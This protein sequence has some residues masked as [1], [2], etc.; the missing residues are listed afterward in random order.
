MSP[1][2]PRSRRR[3]ILLLGGG[4]VLVLAAAVAAFALTRDT[5]DVS[6]PEVEF[7]SEPEPPAPPPAR[8]ARRDTFVWP[9][10]GYT[11]DRRRFLP[12]RPRLRPPLRRVWR[13]RT[14]VLLE[15]TPVMAGRWLYLLDDAAVLRAID[16]RTGETRWRRK[17]G[18][19]AA[20]S[21]AYAKGRLFVTIL[22]RAEG[23][24]GRVTALR[25]RD[26]KVLW[27]EALPSRSESSPVVDDGQVI[28]GS[29][30]GTVY[31]VRASNGATRWR[32]RAQGAVKGGPA[33][34]DGRLYF[35]DYAGRVYAIRQSDGREVWQVG[36][37]GTRFGF[38]SGRF[39]ATPAVAFGRVYLG[40]T[41][42]SV[43][44]FAKSSGKLAWRTSTGHYVYASPAVA[45]L[46][47]SRPLVFTGSYDG[48]FY[49]MDARSGEVRWSYA[50]GGK[51]SGGATV[52]GD[53]V[54]VSNTG[55]RRTTALWA[56]TGKRRWSF[57]DGAYAS[58]I[59][60]GRWI[61]LNGKRA[62]YGFKPKP[63]RRGR[64]R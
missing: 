56:R 52:V 55:L 18:A 53:V 21:P 40:N 6:H 31:S 19:L 11:A 37:S 61:F 32:F 64:A 9:F 60:D 13:K 48:R 22:A 2:S 39:Y 34:S 57:P 33:L 35:G 38:G 25:A 59:S 3:R 45:D 42:G 20:S 17:L 10:F 41:D 7:R 58:V 15:F 47:R 29:E 63:A 44:S 28:F 46:A 14:G 27:S 4:I 5:G 50:D 26:G 12:A 1:E 49:A 43:Y 24:A 8:R 62:I 51:I 16:K 36:T 54:Y 23:Q 30:D